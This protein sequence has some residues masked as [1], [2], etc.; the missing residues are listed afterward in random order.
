MTDPLAPGVGCTHPHPPPAQTIRT[1]AQQL[2]RGEAAATDGAVR[3]TRREQVAGLD[4]CSVMAAPRAPLNNAPLARNV[5]GYRHLQ[6]HSLIG[7][8]SPID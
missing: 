2:R 1:H 8:T 4:N 5:M 6:E 3:E 7:G